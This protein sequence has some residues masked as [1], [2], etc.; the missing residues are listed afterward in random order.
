[1]ENENEPYHCDK[2][3]ICRVGGKD[4]FEHCDTCGMC[5]K[6]DDFDN[7]NCQA[8]ILMAKAKCPVCYEDLFSSRT[9]CHELPCN[10]TLHW[11]CFLELSSVDLRCPICKKTMIRR[12]DMEDVWKRL[13]KDIEDQPVPPD[14]TRVVDVIC[15]DC[16]TR[17]CDRRWHPLGVACTHCKG[18]N[19][20]TIVKMIGVGAHMYLNQIEE[21]TN[22]TNS[23]EF[24]GGSTTE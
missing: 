11:K 13:T 5:I 19:T 16:E 21:A 6:K 24:E 2:C 9:A 23:L 7:H 1:M 18:Y 10:H 12:E 15:N 17:E 14:E 8:G 20:S 22:T 4:N 3:G